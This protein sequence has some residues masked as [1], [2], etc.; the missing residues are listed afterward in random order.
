MFDINLIAFHLVFYTSLHYILLTLNQPLLS[1]NSALKCA[2]W[3][4]HSK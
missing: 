2:Q 4:D 1:L 3:A